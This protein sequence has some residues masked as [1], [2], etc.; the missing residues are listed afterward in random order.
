M[1]YIRVAT[2]PITRRTDGRIS[3]FLLS[4]KNA[5][6]FPGSHSPHPARQPLGHRSLLASLV[7]GVWA[8]AAA[9]GSP[10]SLDQ[11]FNI[12][13]GA[14]AQ[15]D[16]IFNTLPL[17]G[18]K[19]FVT[20]DF[21]NFD[22]TPVHYFVRLN[23]DGSVDRPFMANITNEFGPNMH[24][25]CFC[26]QPDG[27]LLVSGDFAAT[28]R[29][30]Y[31]NFA[32]INTDGTADWSF[33][34]PP[35]IVWAGLT[36]MRVQHDA[37]I[38]VGGWFDQFGGAA[39]SHLAR[40]NADGTLDDAFVGPVINV[41]DDFAVTTLGFQSDGKILVG[42]DIYTRNLESRG[43]MRL[44][45]DGSPDQQFNKNV[46]TDSW[47]FDLRVL[48]DDSI[49]VNQGVTSHGEHQALLARLRPDGTL[50]SCWKPFNIPD[51]DWL[52][53]IEVTSAG[54]V[55]IGGENFLEMLNPD[56]SLDDSF[57]P[58]LSGSDYHRVYSVTAQPDGKL[59]LA[60]T[61]R[62]VNGLDAP[63]LAR[64]ESDLTP[65]APRICFQTPDQS[66]GE[67]Q[68]TT[69]LAGA[70]GTWPLS[71]QWQVNGQPIPGA[72]KAML[73]LKDLTGTQ[74]GA[75]TLVASNSA[76]MVTNS[77]IILQVIPQ[78]GGS[79]DPSFDP[80]LGNLHLG[81]T[82]ERPEIQ[83]WAVAPN[84]SIYLSGEFVGADGLWRPRLARFYADGFV[85][86]WFQVT[87]MLTVSHYG[88]ETLM[89][90]PDHK[91]LVSDYNGSGQLSRLMPNGELDPQ[92]A[93][94]AGRYR[95]LAQQPDGK[96]L[97]ADAGYSSSLVARLNGDGSPDASFQPF[98]AGVF[99]RALAVGDGGDV[100]LA[101][102]DGSAGKVI[103]LRPDGTLDHEFSA[104][105]DGDVYAIAPMSAGQ[106]LIGGRFGKVADQET[107][108][109]ARLNGDGTL[110]STFVPN[111]PSADAR[112]AIYSVLVKG[113]GRILVGGVRPRVLPGM[114]D[115]SCG[116]ALIL[117]LNADGAEDSSFTEQMGG[118]SQVQCTGVR[119]LALDVFGEILALGYFGDQS[120]LHFYSSGQPAD[121]RLNLQ[122]GPGQ[123]QSFTTQPDGHILIQGQ[124]SA[125]DGITRPQLA[126][127]DAQGLLDESFAPSLPAGCSVQA[128]GVQADGKIVIG[129]HC[130]CCWDT[131]PSALLRFNAD[132]TLDPS[133]HTD[134]G[135]NGAPAQASYR[136]RIQRDD[137]ILVS[138]WFDSVNGTPRA[139]LARL[140]ADG[141]L[142]T[143][144]DPGTALVGGVDTRIAEVIL[145]QPDDKI[146]VGGYF[147]TVNGIPRR[148]LARLNPD[149][150]VDPSFE[151]AYLVEH[152]NRLENIR[153]LAFQPDGQLLV[154]LQANVD[155]GKPIPVLIRLNLDGSLDPS[156][157]LGTGVTETSDIGYVGSM[158]IQPDGKIIAG[159]WFDTWGGVAITNLVRLFPSGR[160][161]PTFHVDWT[162]GPTGLDPGGAGEVSTMALQSDSKL[163]IGGWF[164]SIGGRNTWGL[165]RLFTYGGTGSCLLSLSRQAGAWQLRLDGQ[166]QCQYDVQVSS[167][168][169]AWTTLSTVTMT[170]AGVP[171]PWAPAGGHQFCRAKLVQ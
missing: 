132:G 98:Q 51:Q 127:V 23:S 138:G 157:Q 53:V 92:F 81:L 161:D 146:L 15:W 97:Y 70:L 156:F 84:G 116:Y 10:G 77:P 80:T 140:N 139:G 65:T 108:G 7:L 99:V 133:F 171:I 45:P 149:G 86:S 42:G 113:D 167:D 38:L 158:A 145:V 48:P 129:L 89:V 33:T 137:R 39:R 79:L 49:L 117:Q 122:A 115:Y 68:S 148:M 24:I 123:V 67:G 74:S 103:W 37:K 93:A 142:D 111:M 105:L 17:A 14:G 83:S 82:Q 144:F 1:G 136:L 160:M 73:V 27:K 40:L 66:V 21:T 159:G 56:G 43:I 19:L 78:P 47:L 72:T 28:S 34:P 69:L 12:G 120:V 114:L 87:T 25:L 41:G 118:P 31:T 61:F 110:D 165:A 75:Y 29:P 16:T 112:P 164:K 36:C 30:G 94:P 134:L 76:G 4:M 121:F 106:V 71:L 63:G 125:I 91:L 166:P 54:R 151:A 35:V 95:L 169:K 50:D 90:Q 62:F 18:G 130:E 55:V 3:L 26:G 2:N 11:T 6:T 150:S 85:D 163:L 170:T 107:Q 155:D 32:R 104:G 109:L 60:G 141:T 5:F 46:R 52:R 20:G 102:G 88:A 58:V 126:R 96:I 143:S 168:L 119:G 13:G 100:L 101:G 44:N 57:H 162:D 9:A 135:Y 131:G 8:A 153:G 22:G 64:L 128:F 124:F 147:E 154:G 59:L 152:A